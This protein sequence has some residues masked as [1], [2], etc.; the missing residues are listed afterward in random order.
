MSRGPGRA[1]AAICEVLRAA[2]G[3]L[4]FSEIAVRVYG[5]K[6]VTGRRT[7]SRH[8]TVP[9]GNLSNLQRALRAL[10][11]RGTVK[12]F[13]AS[14]LRFALSECFTRNEPKRASCIQPL[15]ETGG[16]AAT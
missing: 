14:G 8:V 7:L 12:E 9:N 4:T 16:G 15:T 3:P 5:T 6:M 2:A 13:G 1:M 10:L 11:R